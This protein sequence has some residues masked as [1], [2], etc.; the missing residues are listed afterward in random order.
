MIFTIEAE[1]TETMYRKRR[2]KVE[3]DS[4]EEAIYLAKRCMYNESEILDETCV[5]EFYQAVDLDGPKIMAVE[6]NLI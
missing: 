5:D 1:Y 6:G 3:A 2:V 4:T